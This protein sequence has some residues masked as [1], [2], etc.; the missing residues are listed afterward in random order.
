MPF[1]YLSEGNN[2]DA[3][4]LRHNITYYPFIMKNCH[5]FYKVLIVQ[6]MLSVIVKYLSCF[7]IFPLYELTG[8]DFP[9]NTKLIM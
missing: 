5:A 3:R 9:S 2:R 8:M 4:L 1:T 7:I 6:V